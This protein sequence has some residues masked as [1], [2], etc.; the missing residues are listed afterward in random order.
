MEK[1]YDPFRHGLVSIGSSDAC[2]TCGIAKANQHSMRQS[3]K[4]DAIKK[5]HAVKDAK[6]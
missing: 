2:P 4:C 1:Q 6:K 5:G 3:A